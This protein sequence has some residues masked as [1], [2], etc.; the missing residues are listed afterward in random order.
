M[1][2]HVGLVGR[3]GLSEQIYQRIRAQIDDGRLTSGQRLPSSRALAERLSVSRNTVS[4]AY[5]RLVAGGAL[6]ARAGLGVVVRG[7]DEATPIADRPPPI[8]QPS[9]QPV[10]DEIITPSDLSATEPDFDLRSGL[11]SRQHFP[12]TTWRAMVSPPA[13]AERRAY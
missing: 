11:P 6:E 2:L 5:D 7:P 10:W 3:R 12:Y 13:P 9:A 1:D 4:A 8:A